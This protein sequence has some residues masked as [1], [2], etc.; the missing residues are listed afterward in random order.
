M[1]IRH[2]KYRLSSCYMVIGITLAFFSVVYGL[3]IYNSMLREMQLKK[4]YAYNN[5]TNVTI[6]TK[7][8]ME[9]VNSIDEENGNIKL[10][11]IK[12][13]IKGLKY[14]YEA[15]AI[16]SENETDMY[17]LIS[18]RLP[19]VGE[20]D[21]IAIGTGLEECTYTKGEKHYIEI[22]GKE[23]EV[24]GKIGVE[25]TDLQKGTI[26]LSL[27]G[28][29]KQMLSAINSEESIH[30]VIQSNKD[31]TEDIY[32]SI[33]KGLLPADST[34]TNES[35]DMMK[36]SLS[37]E[38]TGLSFAVVIYLFSIINCIIVS[39]FWIVQRKR[40][41]AV[42]K[43]FGWDNFD[44]VLLVFKDMFR[45]VGTTCLISLLLGFILSKVFINLISLSIQF[46]MV[47]IVT[48][49]IYIFMTSI[50][51]ILCP[52]YK[53]TKMTPVKGVYE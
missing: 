5:Q 50:I 32:K 45:L 31:S 13:Y 18:G 53:V 40:E 49:V 29:S 15:E 6:Q 36:Q 12:T 16:I 51:S 35:L 37:Y 39:E 19:K 42:R 52:I 25:G 48:V 47:N 33:T 27:A 9:Y 43:A 2:F 3:N 7:E 44:V 17:Q 10:K 14:S 22:G 34:F 24:V 8:G 30:L 1:K 38:D 11:N 26:I 46:D 20:A 23:Y 21:T 28:L 4:E 41:I